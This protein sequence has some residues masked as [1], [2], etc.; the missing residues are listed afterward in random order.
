[1][2]RFIL[3]PF[4]VGSIVLTPVAASQAWLEEANERIDSH[5]KGDLT[6]RVV[7]G[8]GASVQ[9]ASV[10]LDMTRHAFE[11]GTAV[12]ARRINEAGATGEIYREKLLENFNSVVFENDTKWPAW[13]GVWGD[14]FSPAQTLQSLDWLDEN[15]LGARGHPLAWTLFTGPDG[16]GLSDNRED[17]RERLFA[18]IDDKVATLGSRVT[19]W[20][21]I[22]HPVGW[23]PETYEQEYGIEVFKQIIDHAR[24]TVPTGQD[25]WINEDDITSGGLSDEYARIIQYLIDNDAA[26]DGI[27]IQGHISDNYDRV[28]TPGEVYAQ[29]EN[30]AALI[31]R[32]KITELDIDTHGDAERQA[33]LM[34]QYLTTFFSHAAV[35]GVVQWGFW[36]NDHWL[37]EDAALY[38]EDWSER[39]VLEAYQQLVFDEW[40]TQEQ[41]LTDEDGELIVR[42]FL[43]DYNALIDLDGVA[44]SFT[45]SLGADGKTLL[46]VVP[47]PGSLALL[48]TALS[49]V[50]L[51]RR[52]ASP[53]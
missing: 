49:G 5:R 37:G 16:H 36:G 46:V 3:T 4:L 33:E 47:E 39:P 21:V 11:F 26:P 6:V 38:N 27:G 23:G 42:G 1:M 29:L 20:D 24:A 10:R 40:W 35:E 15:Q 30:M 18:H 31:P 17:L 41:G 2:A 53:I 43:G 52:R 12:S 44:Q 7:D 34:T 50:L 13:T 25:L 9:G 45:L 51:R 48:A 22:N 28:R 32:L 19:E 14:D 8:K